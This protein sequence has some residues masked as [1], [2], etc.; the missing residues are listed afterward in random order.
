VKNKAGEW[1]KIPQVTS[2]KLPVLKVM[3][4]VQ[5]CVS[6]T[7][8]YMEAYQRAI[9][10]IQAKDEIEFKK[11]TF[12]FNKI[13]DDNK[14]NLSLPNENQDTVRL[15]IFNHFVNE[16]Y[17][18]SI[19]QTAG[20]K[21]FNGKDSY[22]WSCLHSEPGIHHRSFGV[23]TQD[24]MDTTEWIKKNIPFDKGI[25]QPPYLGKFGMYSDHIGF[26]DPKLDQHMMYIIKGYYA[27]ALHRLRS[28][29]G[30]YAWE[31][32]PGAKNKGLGPEGRWYFLDLTKERI[33]KIH[34]DYPRYNYLLTENKNLQG[35]PVVYSNSSLALYDISES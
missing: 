29:A 14:V 25:I 6:S 1:E 2:G 16:R 12:R 4:Y 28:V 13:Y 35:Y 17:V 32:E 21:K 26:W 31:I 3:D 24:Y 18:E 20:L 8:Q 23:S 10:A 33:I 7:P 22:W 5:I 27:N 9:N 34:R 15:N 30:P 19:S 11:A